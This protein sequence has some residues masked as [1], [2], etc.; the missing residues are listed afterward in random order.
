MKTNQTQNYTVEYWVDGTPETYKKT[1][2][3]NAALKAYRQCA[4]EVRLN[5]AFN[6]KKVLII[7]WAGALAEK[8]DEI[9]GAQKNKTEV[10]NFG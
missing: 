10:L 8:S 6:S 9:I 7:L 5:A 4:A 2:N 1:I 3:R